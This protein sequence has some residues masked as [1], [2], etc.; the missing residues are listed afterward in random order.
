MSPRSGFYCQKALEVD[1]I[2]EGGSHYFLIEDTHRVPQK[3]IF[4]MVL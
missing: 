1:N 2:C 3:D 4:L